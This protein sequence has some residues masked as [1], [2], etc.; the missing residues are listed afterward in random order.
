M[1]YEPDKITGLLKRIYFGKKKQNTNHFFV[2]KFMSQ[3]LS[4]NIK[5]RQVVC[6][7]VGYKNY[8]LISNN[9]Y[10]V[11]VFSIFSYCNFFIFIDT[12]PK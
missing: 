9:V 8:Q 3:I 10:I 11:A 7:L 2:P 4:L 5:Y 6:Q 1:M 12:E